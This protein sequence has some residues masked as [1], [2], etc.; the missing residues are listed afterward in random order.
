MSGDNPE[1]VNESKIKITELNSDSISFVLS[2]TDLAMANG[3]RRICHGEVPILAI[4]VVE[5]FENDSVMHDEF[6]GHRLGLVPIDSSTIDQFLYRHECDCDSGCVRCEVVF[7]LDVTATPDVADNNTLV[8]SKDL[9]NV[10]DHHTDIKPILWSTQDVQ[11]TEYDEED[12]TQQGVLLVK[13]ARNQKVKLIAKAHK[14]IG[15]IHTKFDPCSVVAFEYDPDNALRHTTFEFPL[16]WP[17][18]E[19][20]ESKRRG[21]AKWQEAPYNPDAKADTFYMTV[22]T[23]L[24]LAPEKVVKSALES[25]KTKLELLK[26]RLRSAMKHDPD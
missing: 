1:Y 17:I 15:K 8:T 10:D 3:L 6:L 5:I 25:L 2:G 24:A 18:S 20:S 19:Y 9:K 21:D 13:L 16:D 4:D 26:D 22:E 11:P 14:G 23:T 7:A 12:Q